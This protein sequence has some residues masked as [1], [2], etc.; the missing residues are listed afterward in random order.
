MCAVL[1]L[2]SSVRLFATPWTVVCQAPLSIGFSRQ[3]HRSGLPIPPP[4]DLPDPWIEPTSPV[5]LTL[6][7]DSLPLSHRGSIYG[8]RQM[9]I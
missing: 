6:Q 1:G 8:F 3:E 9:Y 7:A 5:V 2:F 4:G